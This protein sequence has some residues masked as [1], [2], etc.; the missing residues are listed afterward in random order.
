MPRR[1]PQK[2]TQRTRDRLA[3]RHAT[4]LRVRTKIDDHIGGY[5]DRDR[6]DRRRYRYR[7]LDLLRPL[8]VSVRLATREAE[9]LD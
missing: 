2:T 6:N 9:L 3:D 1:L 4:V 8:Q 7:S 5:F